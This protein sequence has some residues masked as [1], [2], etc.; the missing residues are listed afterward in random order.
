[1]RVWPADGG[2]AAGSPAGLAEGGA[3]APPHGRNRPSTSLGRAAQAAAVPGGGTRSGRAFSGSSGAPP[4]GAR[5]SE[6]A[7]PEAFGE[8]EDF[9]DGSNSF[10]GI[11]AD[12]AAA[13]AP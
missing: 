2:A 10:A 4:R 1:M 6:G 13:A 11:D 8:G 12:A 9:D 5:L 3:A 7:L